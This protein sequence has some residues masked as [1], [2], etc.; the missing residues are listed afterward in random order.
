MTTIR[1]LLTAGLIAAAAS[2]P[3]AADSFYMVVNSGSK[4]V[5]LFNKD[6]GAVVNDQWIDLFNA[7]G[8]PGTIKDAIQ[9][10]NE[11]W[12]AD[13]T[14][15]SI[16]RFKADQAN[17][18]YIGTY[19]GLPGVRGLA[20]DGQTIY[21][22]AGGGSNYAGVY[23][24]NR[25]GLILSQ[26]NTGMDSPF[27]VYAAGSE[28]WVSDFNN[29]DIARFQP[30]GTYVADLVPR[31]TVAGLR[32]PEQIT[33]NNGGNLL[34]AGFSLPIGV[35]V[36]DAV[37]GTQL[38]HYPVGAPRGVAQLGNGDYIFTD[39]V[40]LNQYNP[41]T[42]VTIRSYGGAASSSSQYINLV[43]FDATG[44]PADFN[45]DGFLDF[46]DFDD[47]VGA[48]E[49]GAATADFNGDGFLDFTDFDDFVGAFE[50]GC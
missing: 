46:T 22:S 6:T 45:G 40:G 14:A 17:P 25:G 7:T 13:S 48:F 21:A 3:A 16:Y 1:T 41:T 18:I 34:V 4:Y 39:G 36:F 5:M 8:T 47:F 43:D 35:Y 9:V 42:N 20:F 31:A 38:N 49:A 15:G 10:L 26:F 19:T 37:T 27:D 11:I 33:L 29:D 28:V 24:L 44:C 30:D 32:K 50:S 12:V 23:R 2:A